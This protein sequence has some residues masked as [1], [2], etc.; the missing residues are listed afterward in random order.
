MVPDLEAFHVEKVICGSD[1]TYVITASSDSEPRHCISWGCNSHAKLGHS[2]EVRKDLSTSNKSSVQVV[3][4]PTLIKGLEGADIS[5]IA[6]GNSHA[7]A[8][9]QQTQLVYGW[10]NGMNGRLGNES[11]EVQTEPR[12][13]ECFREA[14]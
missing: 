3:K 6:C 9:S 11:E 2:Y 5:H 14:T 1:Q 13:L 12:I 8:W 4:A 10:G 7:F